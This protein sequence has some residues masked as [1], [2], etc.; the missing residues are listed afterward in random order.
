[1]FSIISHAQPTKLILALAARHVHAP[2][3]LLDRHFALRARLRVYL[4]P[5]LTI[6][7][8]L[9]HPILPL[10][11]RFTINWQMSVLDTFKAESLTALTTHIYLLLRVK[12]TNLAA[13]SLGTPF[14]LT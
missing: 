7:V 8:P 6:V 11:Q 9:V 10:G 3:V 12:E 13:L 1:M 14:C 5:T 2:G 4:D